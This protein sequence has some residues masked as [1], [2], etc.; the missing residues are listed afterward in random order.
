[1][2][3]RQQSEIEFNPLSRMELAIL[4]LRDAL[5]PEVE[6]VVHFGGYWLAAL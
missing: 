2:A 5:E 3:L 6:I 1:M 4:L